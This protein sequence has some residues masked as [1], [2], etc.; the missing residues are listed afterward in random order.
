MGEVVEVVEDVTPIP[1]T[2]PIGLRGVHVVID[3]VAQEFKDVIERKYE[4]NHVEDHVHTLVVTQNRV[5]DMNVEIM[6]HRSLV[7]VTACL[8]GQ[9]PAVGM[10]S[11][12]L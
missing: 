8:V 5:T 1:V 12:E 10:V 6:E 9:E 3:V 2:C 11:A 7:V 4:V